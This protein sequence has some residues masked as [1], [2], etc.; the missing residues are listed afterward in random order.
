MVD[1]LCY[2]QTIGLL[3]ILNHGFTVFVKYR[4]FKF[5]GSQVHPPIRRHSVVQPSVLEQEQPCGWAL[6]DHNHFLETILMN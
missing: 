6:S 2:K 5:S 4:A 3:E 1:G